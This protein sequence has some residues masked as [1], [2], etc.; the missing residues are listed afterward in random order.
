MKPHEWKNRGKT[1]VKKKGD[2]KPNQKR[3][4]GNKTLSHKKRR[5]KR[6]GIE[7]QVSGT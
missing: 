4:K 1:R 2:K 6:E 3:E 5:N 7:Y